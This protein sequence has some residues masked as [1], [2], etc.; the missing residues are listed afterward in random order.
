MPKHRVQI[1]LSPDVINLLEQVGGSRS[2]Y[3]DIAVRER[4]RAWQE[5]LGLLA[6]VGWSRAEVLAC[7]DVLNGSVITQP[8][9]VALDLQSA[10]THDELVSRRGLDASRWRQRVTEVSKRQEVAAALLT[11]VREYW[12]GNQACAAAIDR[13]G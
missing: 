9:E 7:C 1:T 8:Q 5:G 6:E 12:T 11:V 10:T 3:L 13:L 4:W 2:E